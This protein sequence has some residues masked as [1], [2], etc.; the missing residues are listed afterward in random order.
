M[1][2][3]LIFVFCLFNE[4]W[5]EDQVKVLF[6]QGHER[7]KS[8]SYRNRAKCLVFIYDIAVPSSF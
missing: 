5:S 6:R 1:T 7:R 4:A 8:L 2:T 3:K